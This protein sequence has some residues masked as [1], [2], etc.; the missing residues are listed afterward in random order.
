M[1]NNKVISGVAI[2]IKFTVPLPPTLGIV[3]ESEEHAAMKV[4]E[5]DVKKLI[6]EGMAENAENVRVKAKPIH[7][8]VKE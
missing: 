1:L 3:L 5:K 6:E 4:L 2:T 7:T 8:E